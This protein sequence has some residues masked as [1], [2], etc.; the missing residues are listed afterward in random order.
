MPHGVLP[1]LRRRALASLLRAAMSPQ[2][3]MFE[4]AEHKWHWDLIRGMSV[5]YVQARRR[6]DLV[7]NF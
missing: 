3:I 1:H 7:C 2:C 6:E 5:L 4:V